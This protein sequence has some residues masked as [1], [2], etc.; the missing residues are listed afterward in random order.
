MFKQMTWNYRIIRHPD[1]NGA[2]VF[3]IHEVY[4]KSKKIE[5]RTQRAIIVGDSVTD[6]KEV[7][8]LIAGAFK[9]PV[10][11]ESKKRGRKNSK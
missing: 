2:K 3:G 10:L 6:L 9:V 1:E 8:K 11:N 7:L 5:S 4:Y